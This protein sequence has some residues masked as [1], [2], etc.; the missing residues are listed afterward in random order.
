MLSLPDFD[1]LARQTMEPTR[2]A[3]ICH[4]AGSEASYRNNLE[5]FNRFRFRPRVMVNIT[6]VDASMRYG[7]RSNL[8]IFLADIDTDV[9]YRTSILGH[10]FDA[11]FFISPFAQAGLTNKVA[12]GGLVSGAGQNN[13]LYIV[14][15]GV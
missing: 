15:S 10:E 12:E 8:P 13:V 9:T 3:Y 4:G 14:G 11:P 7:Y 5:A 2:Y 6:Q 1:Y